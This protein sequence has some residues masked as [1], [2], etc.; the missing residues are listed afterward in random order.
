MKKLKLFVTVTIL[1]IMSMLIVTGC[2][3]AELGFWNLN[4]KIN[5]IDDSLITGE[6]YI[7]FTTMGEKI[8]PEYAQTFKMLKNLNIKYEMRNSQKPVKF[9]L[10][11][12]YKT[13]HMDYQ[14][15][16]NIR[17]VDGFYYIEVQPLIKFAEEYLPALQTDINEIKVLLQDVDYIKVK[18]PPEL[19]NNSQEF[20]NVALGLI[21]D[22]KEILKKYETTLITK[23]GDAYVLEVDLESLFT[24]LKEFAEF[25][26]NNSDS[27]LAALKQNIDNIDE[28]TLSLMLNIPKEDLNKEEMKL[29]LDELKEEINTNRD[30]IR[31][32][33]NQT[34]QMA[35]V[36]TQDIDNS[37]IKIE[38]LEKSDG[39]I[40]SKSKVDLTF[41]DPSGL[42]ISIF[43]ISNSD[44][45][46]VDDVIVTEPR[47]N[48]LDLEEFNLVQ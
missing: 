20:P 8:P 11:L 47:G 22:L 40:G 35:D 6:T 36:L 15:L 21:N 1:A 42:G 10:D 44:I 26:L 2:T 46:E 9:N 18:L 45:Q 24:S 39:K 34:Y 7:R 27:L 16:T 33:I 38:M 29:A 5:N 3:E 30:F 19:N 37:L 4:K 48:I 12:E 25:T 13:G 23:N 43:A 31:F 28:D 14:H 41:T 32:Q 17:L